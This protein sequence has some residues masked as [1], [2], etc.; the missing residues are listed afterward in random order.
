MLPGRLG[1]HAYAR[2][3]GARGP[4]ILLL[5]AAVALGGCIF[6][7]KVEKS[8]SVGDRLTAEDLE[9]TVQR[10]DRRPPVPRKDITGLS[11]PAEGHRLVGILVKVCTDHGSAI[12]NFSFALDASAGEARPKYVANNYRRRFTTVRNGC[13]SGWIAYEIPEESRPTK[14]RFSFSDTAQ[15]RT[16]DDNLEARFEW[17]VE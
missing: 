17:R 5:A 7:G 1:G 11:L 10:V 15:V 3:V 14:V 9:V 8:G 4:T 12:G 16:G 6:G 2:G 13:K